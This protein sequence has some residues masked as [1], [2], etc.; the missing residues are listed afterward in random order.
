MVKKLAVVLCAVFVAGY[1]QQGFCNSGQRNP[2]SPA[3][4]EFLQKITASSLNL[5]PE[6]EIKLDNN[7]GIQFALIPAGEFHMGSPSS[8]ESSQSDE[9]PLHWVKI[10]NPFYMGKYEVTQAQYNIIVRTQ[11]ECKFQGDSLPAENVDWTEVNSF[12]NNLSNKFGLKF[13][14]PTEAEWE[15]ACR[16]GTNT[17][18]YTGQT[19]N[20]TQANYDCRGVYGTGIKGIYIG[21][22]TAVGSYRPNAFG[23]YDMHGNV[24]EWCSD[25]YD[26]KYYDNGDMVDPK[27]PSGGK[28]HIIRGGSWKDDPALLRSADRKAWMSGADRKNLGFRV[29][30]ELPESNTTKL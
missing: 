7:V 30:L 19:I 28:R 6:M 22:T 17:P 29:V 8:E 5:P 12:V 15:Y 26:N 2:A 23:L 18:F 27:G 24:W 21:M 9:R 25:R 11:K 1:C 16:A 20:D 13:R 14:L 3:D 4:A 10:S